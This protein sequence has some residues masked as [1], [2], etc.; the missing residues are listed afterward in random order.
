MGGYCK[1]ITAPAIQKALGCRAKTYDCAKEPKDISRESRNAARCTKYPCASSAA[2]CQ[3]DDAGVVAASNGA[4]KSCAE[5]M[6]SPYKCPAPKQYASLVKELCPKSCRC[7]APQC[8][9]MVA[10]GQMM[11]LPAVAEM[12]AED[13]WEESNAA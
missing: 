8:C 10:T 6:Q 9:K 3:D 7:Q 4:F 12:D 5:V 13:T 2:G 11:E 1:I